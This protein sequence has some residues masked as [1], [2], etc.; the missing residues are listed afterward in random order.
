MIIC[1]GENK[2]QTYFKVDTGFIGAD[3]A[4]P[5][6]IAGELSLSPS[7][8]EKYSTPVGSTN[9][10]KGDDALLCL[11]GKSYKISYVIHYSKFPLISINFLKNISE[12]MIVDFINNSVVI[13]LK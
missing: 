5:A 1:K 6:N 9:L 2:F 13:I 8:V 10:Y 11:G 3:V 4:I 7:N 12:V